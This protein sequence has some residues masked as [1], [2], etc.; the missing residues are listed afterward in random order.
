MTKAFKIITAILLIVLFAEI[1]ALGYVASQ[2]QKQ[3]EGRYFY[4]VTDE[5]IRTPKGQHPL[6]EGQ[7]AV[8]RSIPCKPCAGDFYVTEGMR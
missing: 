6:T 2:V 3:P 7:I 8:L 1:A 4:I 5:W